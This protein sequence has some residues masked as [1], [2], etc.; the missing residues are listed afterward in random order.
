MSYGVFETRGLEFQVDDGFTAVELEDGVDVEVEDLDARLL[1]RG[2]PDLNG[3]PVAS[4]A[5]ARLGALVG[6]EDAT[7]RLALDPDT[8]EHVDDALF[9]IDFVVRASGAPVA[10]VQLQGGT[11]GV[12]L[13]GVARDATAVL[14]AFEAALLAAPG[15]VAVCRVLT[16][17]PTQGADAPIHAYGFD[18]ARYLSPLSSPR[19]GANVD[20]AMIGIGKKAAATDPVGRLLEC[21]DKLRKFSAT[22]VRLAD[23][24]D[25]T[26][27]EIRDAAAGVARYFTQALPRHTADEDESLLPRLRGLDDALDRELTEMER[28]HRAHEGPIA[29]LIGMCHAL[30]EAP[31]RLD[32]VRPELKRVAAQVDEDFGVHLAREENIIFPA[33][34]RLLDDEAQ[35]A[36]ANEMS[37]RRNKS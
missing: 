31:E 21:H 3:A 17:D 7:R 28:E 30:S 12:A 18:G 14:E 20:P 22:A 35:N 27:D 24:H 10:K 33:V 25:G 19:D 5:F 4:W 2:L 26:P 36:I 13:L 15:E 11:I 16:L 32:E 1:A 6:G 37:G 34:Q 9:V 29:E 8:V 23:S